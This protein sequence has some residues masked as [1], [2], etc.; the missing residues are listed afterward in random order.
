M[1]SQ[2]GLSGTGDGAEGEEQ[3]QGMLEMMMGQLMSKE[4]LHE[5]IKELN[6][7]FPEYLSKNSS[8]ISSQDKERFEAQIS[9]IKR[10]LV[11]FEAPKYKDD[12]ET[13]KKIVDL[14][15]ELQ[16]YGSP[17]EEIMGPL[18]PGFNMGTDGL[19]DMPEDCKVN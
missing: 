8:T 10:L 15:G 18:P 1:L 12:D 3:L 17:P 5:P 2:L 9:C 13:R 16:S 6:D 4:V 14:M 7:K 19:P 11:E